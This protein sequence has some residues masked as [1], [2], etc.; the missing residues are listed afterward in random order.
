ME[1]KEEKMS[2]LWA[3]DPFFRE[4]RSW[5]FGHLDEAGKEKV[6]QGIQFIFEEIGLV[7]T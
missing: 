5:I 7:K 4:K 6:Y 3:Y 1:K 2:V